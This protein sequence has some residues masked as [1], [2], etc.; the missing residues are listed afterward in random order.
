MPNSLKQQ[1]LA[2]AKQLCVYGDGTVSGSELV[3]ELPH[4]HRRTVFALL[5]HLVAADE[6]E[7]DLFKACRGADGRRVTVYRVPN[8]AVPTTA[9]R[10]KS[11][12]LRLRE[13]ARQIE[14]V[15]AAL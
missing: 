9:Q 14:E 2:K 7:P 4:I 12:A 3:D 5:G 15:A 11:E 13:V 1:V 8:R 6:L 10:L